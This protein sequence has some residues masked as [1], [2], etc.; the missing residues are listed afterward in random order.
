MGPDELLNSA[1]TEHDDAGAAQCGEPRRTA[2]V[3]ANLRAAN[4]SPARA[5]S[6]KSVISVV[7]IGP[8]IARIAR[9][10]GR[11]GCARGTGR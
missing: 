5:A 2:L 1:R 7:K 10:I 3:P 6:V 4:S 9:I 11:S 8:R